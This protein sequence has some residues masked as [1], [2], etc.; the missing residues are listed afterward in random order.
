V[1]RRKF[2]LCVDRFDAAGRRIWGVRVNR[3]WICARYVR[4]D[5]PM[6]TVFRGPQARQPK[7]YLTGY[8]RRIVRVDREI[9]HIT[10]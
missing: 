9:L 6:T 5:V 2:I 4:V 10:A 3:R 1:K 8:C 7:A